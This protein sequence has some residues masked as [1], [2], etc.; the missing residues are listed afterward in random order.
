ME[1]GEALR[2]LG[3]IA[4]TLGEAHRAGVV[5]RDVKPE[6]VIVRTDGAVV[7]LDFGIAKY[8]EATGDTAQAT[9]QLTSEGVM[10]GTPAYL[11]PEQALARDVGPAA[12][13]FALAV[14]AFELLTGK[15]PWTATEVT[16][17]LA[18]L[19]ADTPPAAS[20]FNQTLPRPYDAVLWRALSK[21]PS[22]RFASVEQF[23]EALRAAERGEVVAS[24]AS[25][26]VEGPA[27]PDVVPAHVEAL[28]QPPGL[29][30]AALG[31]RGRR[32]WAPRRRRRARSHPGARVA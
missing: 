24:P 27:P 15:L 4:A 16:R 25:Q 26:S 11:A 28:R 20:A 13:Q 6:N 31:A 18:Q 14:T 17:M 7:L 19:L 3:E 10:M 5:H 1:R 9:T 23:A 8:I 30:A 2:I 12:D 22:A 21:L 29:V 32:R